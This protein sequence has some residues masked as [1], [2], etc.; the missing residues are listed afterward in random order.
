MEEL[1]RRGGELQDMVP[2]GKGGHV[3]TM[4]GSLVSLP[5]SPLPT[6]ARLEMLMRRA[7]GAIGVEA[8]PSAAELHGLPGNVSRRLSR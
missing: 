3:T 7:R 8:S 5:S 1:G 6:T 2:D 4:P